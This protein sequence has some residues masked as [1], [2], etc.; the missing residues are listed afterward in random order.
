MFRIALAAVFV[1]SLLGHA[2]SAFAQTKPST[3][4]P[5]KCKAQA[6]LIQKKG[7]ACL[8]LANYA[9]R[10]ACFFKL[11]PELPPGYFDG[12]QADW[13]STTKT[14][15]NLDKQKYPK[16]CSAVTDNGTCKQPTAAPAQ[17][18]TAAWTPEKCK[19]EAV[20]IQK[21]GEACLAISG[22]TD[23]RACF[24]KI[25]PALPAGY[26][27]KCQSD[28][29]AVMKNLENLDKQKFPKDCSA[30]TDN[31]TCKQP[32]T[33]A[34]SAPTTAQPAPWTPE[35]CKAQAA[36]IVKKGEACMPIASYND[37][38]A[39][40]F[41]IG[42]E[43]PAGYFDKCQSDWTA[44]M[45]TL[46]AKDKQA[47][48]KDCSAVTDNGTCKPSTV[49]AQSANTQAPAVDCQ[50]I[51]SAQ[52]A[53]ALKCVGYSTTSSRASCLQ[54]VYVTI[55]KAGNGRCDQAVKALMNELRPIEKQKWPKQNPAIE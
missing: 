53:Q 35:K 5:D 31:G 51:A 50:K 13:M 40:F 19:A 28:W 49:P 32:T 27:D 42:P 6:V 8:P 30:V 34:Q 14:L 41:K 26:F 46:E 15:E 22:Y 2:T 18:S 33:A 29:A 48:P 36:L 44:S 47:H 1:L 54:A 9:D 38:R 25:G 17:A 4:T 37:R 20:A 7:E 55:E 21:K 10:R 11:G 39:C 43:L 16:D 23:R 12:C 52:N 24:F 3:W 45:A